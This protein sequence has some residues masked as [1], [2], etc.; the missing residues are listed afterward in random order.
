VDKEFDTYAESYDAA[1]DR[2]LALSGESKDYFA[3]ER[4][5]WL[6]RCL[7]GALPSGSRV[8]D[9]GC[10]TGG[11]ATHLLEH[12]RASSIVGV[13]TSEFSL[14]VARREIPD[15]RVSFAPI[16]Q[17]TP[18]ARFDLAFCNG[19]FHHI[20]PPERPAELEY[21]RRS[22][23][24]GG[25]FA[26]WENNPWNPG[27]R[28]VMSRIPFDRDAKVISSPA[29][30]SMLRAAGFEVLRLDYLFIFPNLLRALRPLERHLTKIPAGGQYQVLCRVK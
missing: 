23:V 8:L 20:E 29:A 10:G 16:T 2:G 7:A 30:R 11:A 27:T 12:L 25:Y 4:V 14:S 24:P 28:L 9:Y 26:F 3:R 18:G 19:V 22:L 1:L 15:P 17:D 5:R 6:A 21:I 13:D